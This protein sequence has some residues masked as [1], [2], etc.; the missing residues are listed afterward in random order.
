[1]LVSKLVH[2]SELI[3]RGYGVAY[4]KWDRGVGVFYPIPF[5]LLVRLVRNTYYALVHAGY[6]SKWE[7]MLDRV[8]MQG[9]EAGEIRGVATMKPM[10]TVLEAKVASQLVQINTLEHCIRIMSNVSQDQ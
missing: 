10:Q 5:N 6:P 7:K 4:W 9:K 2:A 1:M 8:Y 3:P